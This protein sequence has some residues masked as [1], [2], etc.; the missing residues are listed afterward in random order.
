MKQKDY[1][2]KMFN[3]IIIIA[4][5]NYLILLL[6]VFNTININILYIS[7]YIFIIISIS[8][9][10]YIKIKKNNTV[11]TLLYKYIAILSSLIFFSNALYLLIVN[12]SLFTKYLLVVLFIFSLYFYYYVKQVEFNQSKK[13]KKANVNDN[14][15]II[16]CFIIITIISLVLIYLEFRNYIQ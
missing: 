9:F 15:K 6:V 10:C 16:R 5:I 14:N 11:N 12:Q 2:K 7:I 3:D 4:I 8:G 1:I 13:F